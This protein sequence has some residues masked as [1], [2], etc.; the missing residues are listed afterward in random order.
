MRTSV[1]GLVA[2]FLTFLLFLFSDSAVAGLW[3]LA[4]LTGVD[5]DPYPELCAVV[6]PSTKDQVRDA[7]K[8]WLERNQHL[9]RD[10]RLACDARLRRA[11][12]NDEGIRAAKAEMA[13][14]MNLRKQEL[15]SNLDT[16]SNCHSYA[17]D[18]ARGGPKIDLSQDWIKAIESSPIELP[19]FS[20]R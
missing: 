20:K 5:N 17:D 12:G 9:L 13:K 2:G 18:V 14:Y 6:D 11:Y 7:R 15:L 10:V 8:K 4:C 16:A 19:D 3:T 1:P